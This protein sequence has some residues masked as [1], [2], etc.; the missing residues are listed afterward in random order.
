LDNTLIQ[1]EMGIFYHLMK[2]KHYLEYT[3]FD[4]LKDWFELMADNVEEAIVKCNGCNK[5]IKNT[6]SSRHVFDDIKYYACSIDCK[7]KI[8]KKH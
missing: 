3:S 4:N 5:E 8:K 6:P 7:L 2:F 1:N